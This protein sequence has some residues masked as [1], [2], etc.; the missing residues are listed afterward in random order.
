MKACKELAYYQYENGYLNK[1]TGKVITEIPVT[2]TV[3]GQVWLTTLCTPVFV[4]EMAVGFLFNEGLINSRQDI[5][6]VRLCPNQD[7]VDIWTTIPIEKPTSWRKTTGCTGGYTSTTPEK[8]VDQQSS[9]QKNGFTLSADDIN[10]LISDLF[11]QQDLYRIS[12]GV[13]TSL[14]TDGGENWISAEDIGRHNTLD[15]ISGRLLLEDKQVEPRILLTTGRI[16]SE[17]LQKSSRLNAAIVVSRTSPSSLSIELA[18]HYKITLIGYARRNRF[19][20]YTCP[21]RI[22]ITNSDFTKVIYPY[23]SKLKSD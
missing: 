6:D 2:F 18:T 8:L 1:I 3:N 16:S 17:M 12:G 14:L 11:C 23:P 21:E 4:R 7:N 9:P 22:R 15:K 13:H 5:A 20:I 19:T 10:R